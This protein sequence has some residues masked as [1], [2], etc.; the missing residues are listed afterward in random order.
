MAS[1]QGGEHT[2]RNQLL[3][4][5]WLQTPHPCGSTWLG[6]GSTYF[7]CA[8]LRPQLLVPVVE[9]IPAFKGLSGWP[10]RLPRKPHADYAYDH[11]RTVLAC[12][13]RR[14]MAAR[15]ARYHVESREQLGR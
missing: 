1:P 14:G 15:I 5:A 8:S 11:E 2:G 7:R 6:V 3:G 13:R 12:L 9:V 4:Q 10:L